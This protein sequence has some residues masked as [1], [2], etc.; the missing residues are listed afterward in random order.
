MMGLLTFSRSK[1]RFLA[2]FAVIL[3]FFVKTANISD[4]S[5]WQISGFFGVKNSYVKLA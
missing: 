4:L 2:S 3:R 1:R 5:I